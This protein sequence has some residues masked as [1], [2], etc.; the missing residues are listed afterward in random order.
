[1]KN[2]RSCDQLGV[3]KGTPEAGCTCQHDS[4][5]TGVGGFFFAPG[6]VE[7]STGTPLCG[8]RALKIGFVVLAMVFLAGYLISVLAEKGHL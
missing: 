4:H 3:C 5:R 7:E 6:V 1:M 2:H 8:E